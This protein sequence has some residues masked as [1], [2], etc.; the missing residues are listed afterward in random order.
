MDLYKREMELCI[1]NLDI[2][3][4]DCILHILLQRNKFLI[5]F[6]I[7]TAG[8]EVIRTENNRFPWQLRSSSIWTLRLRT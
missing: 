8:T 1:A 6:Y 3:A 2:E 4:R 7:E 5:M